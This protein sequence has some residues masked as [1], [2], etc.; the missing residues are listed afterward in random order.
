M[1]LD[2]VTDVLYPLLAALVAGSAVGLERGWRSEPAGFRTHALVCV[3]AAAV[4]L[5]VRHAGELM[6]DVSASSRVAQGIV[7]G[8]GFVGAGVIIREGLSVRGLTT[9]ASVWAL[10]GLGVVF[11]YGRYL[12]GALGTVVILVVLMGLRSFDRRMPRHSQAHLVVRCD[13]AQAMSESEL[14]ALLAEFEITADLMTHKLDKDVIEQ[15]AQIHARRRVPTEALSARLAAA[16]A[17]V[18]F[19][20]EPL[21]A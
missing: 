18:G 2:Q 4:I 7:T 13:A 17:V 16:P 8:I 3:A 5:G 1:T 12:E 21:D 11:G 6:N 9:A 14:R 20:L 15:S 19:D 10:T